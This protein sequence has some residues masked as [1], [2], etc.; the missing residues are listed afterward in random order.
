M[1]GDR[2]DVFDIDANITM[3][4]NQA[5]TFGLPGTK[6]HLWCVN[7]GTTTRVLGN[8]DNDAAVELQINIVDD[9]V[10]ANAYTAADFFL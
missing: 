9:G 4:G 1:G 2:I 3:A 10:L 8:I 5:F 7:A 6:G